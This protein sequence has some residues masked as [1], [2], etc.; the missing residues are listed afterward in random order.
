MKIPDSVTVGVNDWNRWSDLTVKV[1]VSA[2]LRFRIW[3]AVVLIRLSAWL[4]CGKVELIEG[5]DAATA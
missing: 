1:R 3:A 4:A 5:D 2:P